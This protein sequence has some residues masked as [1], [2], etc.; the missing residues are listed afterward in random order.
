MERCKERIQANKAVPQ[1]KDLPRDGLRILA[2]LIARRIAGLK[3]APR[4]LAEVEEEGVVLDA[5][6]VDLR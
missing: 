2:R 3:P 5:K 6:G 4:H 1:Q